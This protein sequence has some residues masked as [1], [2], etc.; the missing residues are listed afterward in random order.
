MEYLRQLTKWDSQ[1]W[2]KPETLFGFNRLPDTKYLIDIWCKGKGRVFSAHFDNVLNV[3][4]GLENIDLKR[5][6][7]I[8]DLAK[9]FSVD[10]LLSR[11]QL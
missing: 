8:Y 3:S 10:P 1:L 5:G 9:G 4:K 7:W 11:D 6:E 2:R